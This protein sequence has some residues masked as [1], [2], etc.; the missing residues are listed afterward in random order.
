[1]SLLTKPLFGIVL[2]GFVL[3]LLTMLVESI[4]YTGGFKFF[5][6]GGIVLGLVNFV[7]RPMVKLLSL[8]L[9]MITGG[10]V[11]VI[12]NVAILWFLSYFLSVVEFRDVTLAFP[13]AQTYVIGAIVF[14]VINWTAHLID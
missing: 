1:M 2:N 10:I 3:Y 11:L 7:I 5:L 8:P 14:G 6:I 12:W 4:E 13:D 9:I